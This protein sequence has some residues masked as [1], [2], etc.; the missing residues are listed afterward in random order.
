MKA[1]YILAQPTTISNNLVT[2]KCFFAESDN[3]ALLLTSN[4]RP[5]ATDERHFP[6]T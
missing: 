1:E 4:I 5:S 6:A 2:L 3:F